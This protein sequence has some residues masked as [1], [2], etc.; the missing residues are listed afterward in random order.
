MK[1]LA[2]FKA[3]PEL[4]DMSE[5]DWP[6]NDRFQIETRFVKTVINP[7]DESALE[8]ALK[9]RDQGEQSGQDIHLTALTIGDG[10]ADAIL[11]T[12]CALKF[13]RA[14]RLES[15]ADS[16]FNSEEAAARLLD[17]VRGA[18]HFDLIIMGGRSAD[19]D[20]ARTP[21]LLAEALGWTCLTQ[22]VSCGL[23]EGLLEAAC[24][25]DDGE[26]LDLARLPLVLAVGNAPASRLR[27]PTLKDRLAHGRKEIEAIRSTYEEARPS[28]ELVSL[29]YEPRERDALIIEGPDPAA[30]ARRLYEDYLKGRL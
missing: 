5:S 4:E 7:L 1:I 21:L 29:K 22:V 26:R 27:V 10:K 3:V 14:A 2:C 30:K 6:P 12:L 25:T 16:P 28:Y 23:R 13:Q 9:L 20:N 11:K 19:G 24:L 17:F 18:G 15:Q 8:L